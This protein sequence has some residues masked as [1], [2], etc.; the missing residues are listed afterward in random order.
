M[1]TLVHQCAHPIK[2]ACLGFAPL[3]DQGQTV[4]Q[5]GNAAKVSIVTPIF[6]IRCAEVIVSWYWE[7]LAL[8]NVAAIFNVM[9][10]SAKSPFFVFLEKL[11]ALMPRTLQGVCWAPVLGVS[12]LRSKEVSVIPLAPVTATVSP[13]FASKENARN[14]GSALARLV[15]AKLSVTLPTAQLRNV[16]VPAIIPYLVLKALTAR[17]GSVS[18]KIMVVAWTPTP[19]TVYAYLTGS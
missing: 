17:V 13:A 9:E 15:L 2:H 7:H 12:V 19:P 10:E 11:V 18:C 16:L 14:L 4:L 8:T 5:N 3:V 1:V 6:L